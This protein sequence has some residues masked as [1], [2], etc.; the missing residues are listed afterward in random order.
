MRFAPT[1]NG[2]GLAEWV[3]SYRGTSQ[4]NDVFTLQSA[5]RSNCAART[6]TAPACGGGSAQLLLAP[7]ATDAAAQQWW[8]QQPPPPNTAGIYSTLFTG[9][10]QGMQCRRQTFQLNPPSRSRACARAPTHPDAAT[11]TSGSSGLNGVGTYTN[12]LLPWQFFADP[13]KAEDLNRAGWGLQPPS[14][15]IFLR[16]ASLDLASIPSAPQYLHLQAC[17]VLPMA[18]ITCMPPRWVPGARTAGQA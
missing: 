6:L 10:Q 2:S 5:A 7:T 17:C 8:F 15:V 1:D 18:C 14:G 9:A 12:A 16:M 4:G 3:V 11:N 13:G